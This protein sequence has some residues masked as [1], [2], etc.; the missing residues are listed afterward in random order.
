MKFLSLFLS[1]LLVFSI[2]MNAELSNQQKRELKKTVENMREVLPR[3]IDAMTTMI[4]SRMGAVL[5]FLQHRQAFVS[6]LHATVPLLP[7]K[8]DHEFIALSVHEAA[9]S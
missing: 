4:D 2:D 7:Q 6:G 9:V 8:C 5:G 3:R 1:L